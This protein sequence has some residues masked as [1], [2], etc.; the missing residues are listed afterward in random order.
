MKPLTF[1]TQLV[2]SYRMSI[3]TKRKQP[4]Q[5]TMLHKCVRCGDKHVARGYMYQQRCKKQFTNISQMS[6]ETKAVSQQK[7][8]LC[9]WASKQTRTPG[10]DQLPPMWV[11]NVCLLNLS[12][13][14]G[15]QRLLLTHSHPPPPPQNGGMRS[16]SG[17]PGHSKHPD[18]P[19]HTHTHRTITQSISHDM[20]TYKL[21]QLNKWT[22]ALRLLKMMGCIELKAAHSDHTPLTEKLEMAVFSLYNYNWTVHCHYIVSLYC[23]KTEAH[24]CLSVSPK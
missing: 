21:N 23:P 13:H 8:A 16:E 1:V 17:S 10:A 15:I 14:K 3:A 9:T 7:H 4:A 22:T 12:L 20:Q 24:I 11:Y 18:L 19:L 6:L 2:K 5:G